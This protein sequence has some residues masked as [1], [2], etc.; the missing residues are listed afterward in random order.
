MVRVKE[1]SN[2]ETAM[3]NQ[4]NKEDG[5]AEVPALLT[6]LYR[7]VNRLEELFPGRKF[8]PD[9]H[10]VGSIGEAMAARMFD[11][12]LLKASTAEHDAISA[13]GESLVQIK[14]T[15]GTRGIALRAEPELLL[16]L[17]LDP[18][19]LGVEVVYNGCGRAPWAVAGKMNRNG[20]RAI[21]L[22]RLRAL[23]GKIHD[24]ERLAVCNALD[25]RR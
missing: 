18:E 22:S 2:F 12:T 3:D 17:R 4:A 13:D 15:Q 1:R 24:S 10:L 6:S 7:V 23:D 16:V 11:L 21:S 5:W 20:Q 9:G 25:L 14:L 19:H 8:T